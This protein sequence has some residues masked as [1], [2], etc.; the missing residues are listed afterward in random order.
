MTTMQVMSLE[1]RAA[2][3]QAI[4]G[5]SWIRWAEEVVKDAA[6]EIV[7]VKWDETGW[8]W[9]GVDENGMTMEN[10][11]DLDHAV[12]VVPGVIVNAIA[13]VHS[14]CLLPCPHHAVVVGAMARALMA[15][16]RARADSG[17]RYARTDSPGFLG[18][19]CCCSAG[20][21][22]YSLHR[23]SSVFHPQQIPYWLSD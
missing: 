22:L 5:A 1:Q 15:H 13:I 12:L 11:F 18:C 17:A 3:L 14:C 21:V 6:D 10:H 7:G 9:I 23:Y 16:P 19:S 8:G 20:T 4:P 2:I